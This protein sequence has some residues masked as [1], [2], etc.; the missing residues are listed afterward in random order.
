MSLPTWVRRSAGDTMEKPENSGGIMR[1]WLGRGR[2]TSDGANETPGGNAIKQG[3]R[4]LFDAMADFLIDNN[5]NVSADN[6]L[7]AFGAFSGENPPLAR[8]IARKAQAGEKITQEWLD[9]A[10]ANIAAKRADDT[11]DR[12]MGT[13]EENLDAFNVTSG[14]AR[15]ATAEYGGELE[16]HVQELEQVQ[17]AGQIIS[18]LA[19][20]A[21]AMAKRTRKLEAEMHKREEE[22]KALRAGLERAKRDAEIDHLTGLPNRRA[23]E[24]L[25]DKHYREAQAAIETLSVAFCDIDHFKRINDTHGHDTGDRVIQAIAESLAAIT[26]DN[27]HVARHGGEEFVMLFRG[28]APAEAHKRLDD[29]RE[30]FSQRSFVNRE[31]DE[32]MGQI[33][34]SGGI[35]DVFRYGD[36][37]AALKAADDALYRAKEGGRNCIMVDGRE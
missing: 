19:G 15:K 6:V 28:L 4:L 31:S 13:L 5:L 22:G 14:S 36:P 25:L 33:T 7:A 12:L 26:N 16:K 29:L 35:A 30:R 1:G 17:D 10:T 3:R 23:F 20:L 24:G 34:F 18:N 2:R 32:S 9:E 11:I 21:K 8:E 37:R 27:C